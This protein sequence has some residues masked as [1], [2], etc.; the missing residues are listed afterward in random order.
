[1]HLQNNVSLVVIKPFKT[2]P[3]GADS[4]ETAAMMVFDYILGESQLFTFRTRVT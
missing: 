1:M 2:F 3:M 4:P